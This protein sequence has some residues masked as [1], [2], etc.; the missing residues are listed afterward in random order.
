MLR[1]IADDFPE[2]KFHKAFYNRLSMTFGHIAH[3]DRNGFYGH[4]FLTTKDK[5]AFLKQCLNWR[6]FGDPT[7]TYCDVERA[8]SER[9]RNTN[10]VALL[11]SQTAVEQRQSDLALLAKLKARYE[12][13]PL[14]SEPAP[15]LFSALEGA[16]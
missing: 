4:F 7:Y 15:S 1:F 2:T 8:V 3:Y 14:P 12:A 9:L 6:C 10:I 5:I 11:Q 13:A 16:Q